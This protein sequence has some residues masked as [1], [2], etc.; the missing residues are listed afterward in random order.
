M[1]DYNEI[2]KNLKKEEVKHLL[3]DLGAEEVI[4]KDNC[5]IT[6]TICHNIEGGSLKLYYYFD[7]HLFYCF[8]EDGP[9]TIYK[10]LENYYKTRNIEYNWG[11]DILKVV[12]QCSA[13]T[14]LT[15]K[16]T[17]FKQ[18]LK[19]KYRKR[20]YIQCTRIICKTIPNRM[21]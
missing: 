15:T 21:A 19:D 6:N 10:F 7:T 12:F 14:E 20:Q 8:T 11:Q 17:I 4:E 16:E 3:L 2:V 9:M 5:F 13:A 18:S 1:I